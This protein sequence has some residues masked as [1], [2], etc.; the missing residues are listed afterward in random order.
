MQTSKP[1]PA[2]VAPSPSAWGRDAV[3]FLRSSALRPRCVGAI[4][5]SSRGLARLICSEIEASGAPVL[6]LGPGTGVF[7]QALLARGI[8]P[9]QLTLIEAL[10]E[11]A[12]LLRHRYPGARVLACDAAGLADAALYPEACVAAAVSGLPLRAMPSEV[13]DAIIAS[14]FAWLRPG[15]CLYQFTYGLRCPIPR[16]ILQRHQLR[17]H[18]MGRVWRNLPPAT[19]YRIARQG[20]DSTCA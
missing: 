11:F 14:V 13:I 1:L 7:T 16:A 4:A 20:A 6:E 2:I 9:M 15:A 5:P 12:A 17:A 8:E 3:V 18:A 19:V 10:P